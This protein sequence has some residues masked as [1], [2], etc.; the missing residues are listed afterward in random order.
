MKI[1]T[2]L[3]APLVLLALGSIAACGD[4]SRAT[5]QSEQPQTHV[6]VTCLSG[7]EVSSDD[8]GVLVSY[9]YSTVTYVSSTTGTQFYAA[10]ECLTEF[11]VTA[12]EGWTPVL[13][14]RTPAEPTD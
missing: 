14:G 3:A 12:P 7:G 8:Y 4:G 10:G 9:G 5:A 11:G 2:I 1:Q 13:P 6:R